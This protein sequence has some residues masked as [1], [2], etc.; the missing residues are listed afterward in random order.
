VEYGQDE[1]FFDALAAAAELSGLAVV[2]TVTEGETPQ[3]VYVSAGIEELLGCSA[4]EIRERTVWSFI[5]EDELPRLLQAQ[6]AR[7]EGDT[8]PRFNE[9]AV[10]RKDGERIPVEM[11]GS[12]VYLGGRKA[13]VSFIRDISFRKSA[14]EKLRQSEERF[15]SLVENA[16][17]GIV[18]LKGAKIVFVNRAAARLAGFNDP[19]QAVGVSMTDLLKPDEYDRYRRH[20]DVLN[21][22]GVSIGAPALYRAHDVESRDRVAEVSS[23]SIQYQGE[24]A[25]LGFVRDVTERVE[26]QARLVQSD[27][28]AAL[29]LLAGGIA[30]EINNPLAYAKLNLTRAA[31]KLAALSG[32]R[33]EDGELGEISQ[34]LSVTEEGLERAAG[35][36]RDLQLFARPA[37]NLEGPLDIRA[38]LERTLSLA[39]YAIG[40]KASVERDYGEEVPGVNGNASLLEQL[41]LNLFIN[42]ARSFDSEDT[43]NNRITVSLRGSGN[44]GVVVE[45]ADNGRGMTAW[46]AQ[47]ALDPFFTADASSNGN[48]GGLGLSICKSIVDE[49]G[50]EIDLRSRPGEGTIFRVTL[51]AGKA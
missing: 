33:G 41:F 36:I 37:P 25:V 4:D 9:F 38:A 34:S 18:I 8:A 1:K 12:I 17:D 49:M 24:P 42:A 19:G 5:A 15:R 44:G 45:V 26:A 23:I 21:R 39:A 50:G 7:V 40:R 14:E 32:E 47:H 11:F 28:L 27:R 35:I 3:V 51:P 46:E 13:T 48:G 10:I 22:T 16:P 2:V 31:R 30:H 43:E 6:R 29:G 20:M